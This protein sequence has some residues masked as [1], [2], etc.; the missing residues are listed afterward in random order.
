MK[1]ERDKKDFIAAIFSLSLLKD[2][3]EVIGRC[4]EIKIPPV[5]MTRVTPTSYENPPW[6]PFG[7]GG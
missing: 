7:K 2:F 1:M 4:Q 3:R 5:F 6:S